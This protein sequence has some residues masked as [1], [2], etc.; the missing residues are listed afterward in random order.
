MNS[1]HIIKHQL[2]REVSTYGFVKLGT[3]NVT[4]DYKDEDWLRADN[5]NPSLTIRL[6]LRTPVALGAI[7]TEY[8]DPHN[9][10]GK[11]I[12]EE[13]SYLDMT[14]D[15]VSPWNLRNLYLVLKA[16]YEE[17]EQRDAAK[18]GDFQPMG[19]KEGESYGA[20]QDPA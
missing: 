6:P 17:D 15:A 12:D 10:S 19:E 4:L 3:I 20:D 14:I 9:V 13:D 2:K 16:Y 7:C 5:R 18:T 11:L 8:E 1:D